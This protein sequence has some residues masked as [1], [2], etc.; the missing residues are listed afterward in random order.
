M[1]KGRAMRPFDVAYIK[2]LAAE[3]PGRS[4]RQLE[5]LT[6][7]SEST[8]QAVLNGSY[9]SLE[10]NKGED[11]LEAIYHVLQSIERNTR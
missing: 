10:E 4:A 1:G 3:Y 5:A 2:S 6:R 9:D 8:I 11:I 7:R